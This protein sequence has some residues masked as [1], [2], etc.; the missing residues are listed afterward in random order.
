[1]IVELSSNGRYMPIATGREEIPIISNA[2]EMNTPIPMQVQSSA[3][4]P[5]YITHL[6]SLYYYSAMSA[7]SIFSSCFG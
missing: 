2:T 1:M 7:D 6:H 4:A 5:A 3:T